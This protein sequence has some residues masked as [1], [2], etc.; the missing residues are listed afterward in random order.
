MAIH[1]ADRSTL[2]GVQN[3]ARATMPTTIAASI[4]SR[5]RTK[6]QVRVRVCANETVMREASASP[7]ATGTLAAAPVN[8]ELFTGRPCGSRA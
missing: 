2:D 6:G 1:S 4:S 8:R 7:R 3:G 5:C